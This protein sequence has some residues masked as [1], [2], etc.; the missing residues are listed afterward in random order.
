MPY[1]AADLYPSEVLFPGTALPVD[2]GGGVYQLIECSLGDLILTAGDSQNVKWITSTLT[3]W[4]G[5]P[6]STLQLTPKTRMA[7]AWPGPRQMREKPISIGGTTIAP[8]MSALRDAVDRLNT[9]ASLDSTLLTVSE[10]GLTRSCIVQRQDEVLWTRVN[11]NAASWS[12]QVV[13][14]D[15]RKFTTA[16][17]TSTA[18]PAATGG[19]TI[20]FTVPFA[21]TSTVVS[22]QAFLTNP[23]NA[24]GPVV[25]RINGP[26]TGPQIT[27][28]G[29]GITLTFSSSLSLGVNEYLIVDM[30]AQTALANG[31]ASRNGSI[32]SRGWFGFEPGANTWAFT[33]AAGSG[34]LTVTATPAWQ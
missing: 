5:S 9:A 25:L 23:G 24:V 15:P 21:I 7:G 4:W 12:V 14:P 1:P 19:L 22:G 8:S 33:A 32:T 3:G 34:L 6:G 10:A 26:I 29:S 2:G 20:P 28:V 30:E 31:Q 27:H 17:S 11:Q 13:A 16:L 18:L